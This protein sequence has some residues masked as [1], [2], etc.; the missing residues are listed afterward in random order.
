MNGIEESNPIQ[1]LIEKVKTATSMVEATNMLIWSEAAQVHRATP[2][3]AYRGHIKVGRAVCYIYEDD[4]EDLA[5]HTV[6]M[7]MNGIVHVFGVK[8]LYDCLVDAQSQHSLTECLSVAGG[9]PEDCHIVE[10]D[11]PDGDR[12][13]VTSTRTARSQLVLR[14]WEGY[15]TLYGEDVDLGSIER[16]LHHNLFGFEWH[17]HSAAKKGPTFGGA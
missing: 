6:R 1:Q 5:V 8:H 10:P 4:G 14:A 9:L 16:R 13:I 12:V 3:G 7:P 17:D 2:T 15:K 11:R